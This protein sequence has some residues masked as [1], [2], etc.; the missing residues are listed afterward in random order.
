MAHYF[1]EQEIRDMNFQF[2]TT[3][4]GEGGQVDIYASVDGSEI[5]VDFSHSGQINDVS[6]FPPNGEKASHVIADGGNLM[7][8]ELVETLAFELLDGDEDFLRRL[9]VSNIEETEDL[10]LSC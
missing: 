2:I 8:P 9:A 6:F 5:R 10:A 3:V 1:A 4:T 7:D